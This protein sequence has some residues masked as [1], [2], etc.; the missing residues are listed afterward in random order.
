MEQSQKSSV[1]IILYLGNHVKMSRM[2]LSF[3]DIRP[4]DDMTPY[5]TILSRHA[6]VVRRSNIPYADNT[7]NPNVVC[8]GTYPVV[9]SHVH[10]CAQADYTT[11]SATTS[12]QP[13]LLVRPVT[14]QG[15]KW[16]ELRVA[17]L[18]MHLGHG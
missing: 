3:S 16:A 9:A 14:A 5:E 4:T 11:L 8:D 7:N 1:S 10:E 18:L 13:P 12:E 6:T 15:T 17:Q 2:I